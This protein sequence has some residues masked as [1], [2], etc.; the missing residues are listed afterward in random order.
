MIRLGERLYIQ[1][2]FGR[3]SVRWLVL[4]ADRQFVL[5]EPGAAAVF[6]HKSDDIWFKFSSLYCTVAAT[7]RYTSVVFTGCVTPHSVL[8]SATVHHPPTPHHWTECVPCVFLNEILKIENNK[9][10]KHIRCFPITVKRTP[11][12][13]NRAIYNWVFFCFFVFFFLISREYF[14]ILYSRNVPI[15]T[16][17]RGTT[18]GNNT[19]TIIMMIII[20]IF[21]IDFVF[22][23]YLI[24]ILYSLMSIQRG[25]GITRTYI[26][27]LLYDAY[28]YMY[29]GRY[30]FQTVIALEKFVFL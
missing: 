14:K 22:V 5:I 23:T 13:R 15:I 30:T 24:F 17:T 27:Y 8:Q 11:G 2:T 29:I 28:I 6:E 20:I 25:Y 18:N 16:W 7:K 12:R 26:L 21:Y 4:G 19:R 9:K 1:C 10:Q 3:Y